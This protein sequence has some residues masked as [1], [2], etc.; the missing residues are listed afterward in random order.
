MPTSDSSMNAA[1][2]GA[3]G[4]RQPSEAPLSARHSCAAASNCSGARSGEKSMTTS[5]RPSPPL[6]T[7]I[8]ATAVASHHE[9]Y[10]FRKGASERCRRQPLPRSST[11][12][13]A[14]PTSNCV[15]SSS[16][17]RCGTPREPVPRFLAR[18]PHEMASTSPFVGLQQ[19]V[20]ATMLGG[21]ALN[22]HVTVRSAVASRKDGPARSSVAPRILSF[23]F[24]SE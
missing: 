12:P 10:V 2:R 6:C 22:A 17:S 3:R 16:L 19:L 14:L 13:R 11:N 21:M 24:C 18:L 7:N 4:S 8:A 1:L 9:R 20:S 5:S 23:L 15:R